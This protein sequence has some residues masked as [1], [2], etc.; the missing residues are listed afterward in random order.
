[1]ETLIL[2]GAD[3][4]MS[5]NPKTLYEVTLKVQYAVETA[6]AQAAAV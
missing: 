2:N 1:M 4:I 5:D 3:C 6:M